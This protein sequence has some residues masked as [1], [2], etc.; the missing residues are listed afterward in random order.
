MILESPLLNLF[1][2]YGLHLLQKFLDSVSSLTLL[3]YFIRNFM[4]WVTYRFSYAM[5]YN[6]ALGNQL[7]KLWVCILRVSSSCLATAQIC[8]QTLW[9]NHPSVVSS[10]K[11]KTKKKQK[12]KLKQKKQQKT[13]SKCGYNQKCCCFLTCNY[14]RQFTKPKIFNNVLL[15]QWMII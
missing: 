10:L 12:Q 15:K 5:R 11:T 8:R 7:L 2:K 9:K 14:N 6:D 3:K 13:K 1:E 4:W